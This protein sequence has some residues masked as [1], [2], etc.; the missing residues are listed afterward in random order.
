MLK[1]AFPFD[2]SSHLWN[3][4]F[5][6][7]W[8]LLK[9]AVDVSIIIRTSSR[10]IQPKLYFC[11]RPNGVQEYQENNN[12]S[13]LSELFEF[14]TSKNA[15]DADNDSATQYLRVATLLTGIN[16]PDHFQY[17]QLLASRM[18]KQKIAQTIFLPARDCPTARAAIET[19]VSCAL[20]KG[21]KHKYHD[22]VAMVIFFFISRYFCQITL[23]TEYDV[24]SFQ[25]TSHDGSDSDES[26]AS[27]EMESDDEPPIKLRR[28]QYTMQVLQSWYDEQ[29]EKHHAKQQLAI[30]MPNFEEFK[31]NVIKD[32]ITI[33]RYVYIRHFPRIYR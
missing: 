10:A 6:R 15:E 4:E 29:Y 30:I 14:V 12:D 2:A 25:N 21:R 27:V 33:L 24:G 32:L 1:T 5:D 23:S 20:N 26:N 7:T 31:G 17:F 28:S 22:D 18:Q 13:H 16:K 19:L 8:N 3:S 9:T 11:S